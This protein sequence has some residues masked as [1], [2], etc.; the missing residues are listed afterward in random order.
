[1][2]ITGMLVSFSVRPAKWAYTLGKSF[3]SG[4][5]SGMNSSSCSS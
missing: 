4:N 3:A 5:S 2:L 1:M